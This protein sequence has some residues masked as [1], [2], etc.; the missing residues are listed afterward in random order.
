LPT[1]TVAAAITV[2]AT[3]SQNPPHAHRMPA[4]GRLSAISLIA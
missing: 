2:P 3:T 1:A 4:S